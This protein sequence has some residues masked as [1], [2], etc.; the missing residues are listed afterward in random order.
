MKTQVHI[1][2]VLFFV[3]TGR[4]LHSQDNFQWS[5]E[6]YQRITLFFTNDVHGGITATEATF[7]NPDF[8]PVIGG[9][10]S[11][12]NLITTYR[13]I[14]E[15]KKWGILLLD[16]GD[17]FQG[18]LL[19]TRTAG[20]AV[21]DYMNYIRYDFATFGNHDFDMGKENVIKL[22]EKAEFPFLAANIVNKSTGEIADFVKPY[23]VKEVRGIK[24]GI[25]GLATR[26]TIAMSYPKHIEGLDFL[27]EIPVARKY[28]KILREEEGCDFVILS[29][30]S[31]LDYWPE[32]GYKNLLKGKKEGKD[33]D[34]ATATC[35]EIAHFVPGID[36]MFG[37][38]VHKG[39]DKPWV[40]PDNH[41]L[42][43][44]SYA[45]SSSALGHINLYFDRK[46]RSFVGYD[47]DNDKGA[48]LTLFLDEFWPDKEIFNRIAERQKEV[49]KGFDDIIGNNEGPLTRGAGESTMGNLV[50]DA[51]MEEVKADLAMSNYGGIR[52][53]MKSGA[54]TQRDVFKVMP[55]DNKIVVMKVN[56]AFI[57]NLIEERVA[58]NSTGML[59]AG[60]RVSVDKNLPDGERVTSL[61]IGGEPYDADKVYSLAISDYLAEG[62]S[63][64]QS[65]LKVDEQYVAHTGISIR[66]A[67]SNYIREH[68]PIS[69]K[70]DGRFKMIKKSAD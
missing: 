26:S 41:T 63:G 62:N 2:L 4:A 1:F 10:G 23:I 45:N 12:A 7:M 55:F 67:I 69:P 3:C 51:M 60:L 37:G 25:F 29:S 32:E 40:E 34:K 43:I 70:L 5:D 54:V 16:Q 24:I 58:G 11:A 27:P 59:V 28:V 15:E 50:V 65:L 8:P 47:F 52:A 18:T 33:F 31:W 48:M 14:A 46:N 38:H 61:E 64:F 36:L 39:H 57:K 17:M 21:I 44:Q 68:T 9:G 49:E 20:D 53:E 42:I 13:K 35:I 66:D 6:K 56:G 30:H 22:S 19:G